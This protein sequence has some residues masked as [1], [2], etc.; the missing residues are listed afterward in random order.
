MDHIGID[1][2]GRDSQV[3]V[4]NSAG[5]IIEARLIAVLRGCIPSSA[6]ILVNSSAAGDLYH[7]LLSRHGG[8]P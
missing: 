1:L 4:R 2:G 5:E 7:G 3:C 6:T 8:E